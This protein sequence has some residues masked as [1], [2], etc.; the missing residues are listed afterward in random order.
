MKTKFT[1]CV[2]AF[3]GKLKSQ[4]LIHC[5]YNQGSLVITRKYP[6]VEIE[7]HHH[8][9]GST[10]K[11]LRAL[12]HTLASE[13]ID[14]LKN[15]TAL[16]SRITNLNEK[17]PAT[18]YGVYVSMMWK[19]KKNFPEIDMLTITRDEILKQEYPIRS[20]LEA[21]ENNI[22]MTIPEGKMLDKKI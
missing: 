15:Y 21:M 16:L 13:Y 20:I 5:K 17:L 8:K 18:Y 7:E 9:F 6:I 19:L 10:G 1:N 4:G 14:D 3:Y 22:L 12:F 11:N 2:K